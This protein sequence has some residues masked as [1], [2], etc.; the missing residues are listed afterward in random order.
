MTDDESVDIF[1]E[2]VEDLQVYHSDRLRDDAPAVLVAPEEK[3]RVE[4]WDGCIR[5]FRMWKVGGWKDEVIDWA[6]GYG[7]AK[8]RYEEDSDD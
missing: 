5:V 4:V 3:G 1:D 7:K 8:S 6:N 2:S